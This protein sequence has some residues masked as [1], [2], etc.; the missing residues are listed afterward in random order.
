MDLAG[1]ARGHGATVGGLLLRAAATAKGLREDLR[2]ANALPWRALSRI[3]KRKGLGEEDTAVAGYELRESQNEVSENQVAGR[4]GS[5][6][7]KK[8]PS[9]APPE[10]AGVKLARRLRPGTPSPSLHR[11]TP[12]WLVFSFGIHPHHVLWV[13]G[14]YYSS[15]L[16]RRFFKIMIKSFCK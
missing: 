12:C 7:L 14:Q 6:G 15:E 13:E 10:A 11:C 4:A 1:R 8:I 5:K 16:R 2:G 3:P 9:A